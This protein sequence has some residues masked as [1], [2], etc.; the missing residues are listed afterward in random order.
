[1]AIAKAVPEMS[2]GKIF[3]EWKIDQTSSLPLL[4]FLET[5]KAQLRRNNLRSFQRSP[6]FNWL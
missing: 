1:M 2:S 3:T 4:G 5:K 6:S